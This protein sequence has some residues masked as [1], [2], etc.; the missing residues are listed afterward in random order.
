MN[1]APMSRRKHLAFVRRFRAFRADAG[2]TQEQLAERMGVSSRTVRN[3]EKRCYALSPGT[4]AAYDRVVS[5][6][7]HQR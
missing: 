6:E 3:V 4:V 2:L 7:A 5:E 1:T